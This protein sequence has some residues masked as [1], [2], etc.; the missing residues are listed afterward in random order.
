M[1]FGK[2]SGLW[3]VLGLV[4]LLTG[5]VTQ[6]S[7]LSGVVGVE[8][9]YFFDEPAYANQEE[10]GGSLSFQAEFRHKWN[11]EQNVLT[12]V[13][14]YRND[15]NDNERT[16]GDIRQLD[17]ITE[18]GDWEFQV[19]ISKVFWGVVE[20][21]HLVD[22]INQTDGVESLDGEEKLGQPMVKFG[23][24]YDGGY[25]SLF[26][27]PY[28]RERTFAGENGRLRFQLPVDVKNVIYESPDKNKHVDYAFRY[29]QTFNEV[30]IGLSYFDGTSRVPYLIPDFVN[31]VLIQHYPLIKQTG[32]DFQYTGEAWLWK[33]EAINRESVSDNYTAAVGGFEYSKPRIAGSRADLGLIAE[34]HTDSRGQVIDALFQNDLFFGA[35]IASNDIDDTEILIGGFFDLDNKTK[36]YTFEASMRLLGDMKLNIEAQYF[37]DVDA[38]DPL[39]GMKDDSFMQMELLKYF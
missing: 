12:F 39:Y 6:A 36:S 27:L 28:F 37:V 7:E 38:N 8:G 24:Q 20:S 2:Q 18:K 31:G 11:N 17:I 30:D 32:L 4:G 23:Y 34:Y 14:F 29:Q 9:R 25:L 19:G 5:Q 35:R 26:V 15:K 10:Q 13:P 33:L 1:M 3:I 21:S 22:I 16:H